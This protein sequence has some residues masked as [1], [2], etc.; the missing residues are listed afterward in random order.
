MPDKAQ[1]NATAGFG[2]EKKKRNPYTVEEK[3]G[4][5]A[6]ISKS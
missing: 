3:R 5:L 2:K 4:S 6:L 1:K